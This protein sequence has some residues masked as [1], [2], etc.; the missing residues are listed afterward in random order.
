MFLGNHVTCSKYQRKNPVL[1]FCKHWFPDWSCWYLTTDIYY[2]EISEENFRHFPLAISSERSRANLKQWLG[3]E[4]VS[5]SFFISSESRSVRQKNRG[6]EGSTIN[7]LGGGAG[8]N[9]Q[10][11]FFPGTPSV[12]IFFFKKA[13]QFFF[14][15][16][17]FLKKKFPGEGPPK[18]FFLKKTQRLK[19][20]WAVPEMVGNDRFLQGAGAALCPSLAWVPHNPD[21][22]ARNQLCPSLVWVP[23][24]LDMPVW[25]QLRPSLAQV[26]YN[27]DMYVHV[28]EESVVPTTVV[29]TT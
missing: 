21:M 7:D 18:F 27:L 24:N 9:F 10:N 23:H 17:G 1:A 29:S 4:N 5:F 13:S 12:K 20:G 28:C 6:L 14:L 19:Q 22:S 2:W 3:A 25:N 15:E 16:K 8:G 11:D 26:P